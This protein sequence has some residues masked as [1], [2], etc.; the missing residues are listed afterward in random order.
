M[1]AS[2]RSRPRAPLASDGKSAATRKTQQIVRYRTG[3]AMVVLHPRHKALS[4]RS[5]RLRVYRDAN[6]VSLRSDCLLEGTTRAA[7]SSL[8]LDQPHLRHLATPAVAA[9]VW[10]G[11]PGQ[12]SAS[13][14]G[15]ACAG[16]S[17]SSGFMSSELEQRRMHLDRVVRLQAD[18]H[19]EHVAGVDDAQPVRSRRGRVPRNATRAAD[20]RSCRRAGTTSVAMLGS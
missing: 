20:R 4:A 10:L 12:A 7:G 16:R 11:G 6:Y 18:L 2:A 19:L 9:A 5:R 15:S 3:R 14:R 8:L 1:T 13:R 17:N